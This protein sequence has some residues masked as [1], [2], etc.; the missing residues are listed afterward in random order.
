MG[1]ATAGAVVVEVL[2]GE[3]VESRHL[4]ALAVVHAA[5]VVHMAWGDVDRPVSA[6]SRRCR[7]PCRWRRAARPM[8][9]VLSDAELALACASV[10]RRAGAC[11]SRLR[12]LARL[13]LTAEH[14]EWHAVARG[15]EPVLR[16]WQRRARWPAAAPT[17][18]PGKHCGFLCLACHLCPRS[19][20]ADL[21][22]SHRG[23]VAPSTR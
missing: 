2:R 11:G 5:G 6:V 20:G 18:A 4:G 17:T 3:T 21:L 19:G 1:L 10:Q 16:A 8:P 22:A 7:R 12:G 13:G 15:G 14:L 23:Y 9:L